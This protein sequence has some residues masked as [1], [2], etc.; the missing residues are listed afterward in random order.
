MAEAAVQRIDPSTPR[1][2]WEAERDDLE[3]VD[4]PG[5]FEG[6]GSREGGATAANANLWRPEGVDEDEDLEDEEGEWEYEDVSD[7]EEE[8]EE[9]EGEAEAEPGLAAELDEDD[10]EETDEEEFEYVE[11]GEGEELDDEGWEYEYVEVDEDEDDEDDELV[12]LAED[13]EEVDDDAGTPQAPAPEPDEAEPATVL[14]AAL[15]QTGADGQQMDLFAD[16]ED[17]A[18][19]AEAAA[20]VRG[21]EP[22]VVLEPQA[23]PAG[24]ASENARRAA[25]VILAESRVAVSLLQ[26]KF[27]MDFKE[28]CAVLDELQDLGFIGP[29]ID[30]KQRDILMGREEWL[31]AVGTG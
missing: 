23:P 4:V 22:V 7:L 9:D 6:D 24:L 29:Y 26:R 3:S 16:P 27:G 15:P 17:A 31:S 28:S 21:A 30:G 1:P 25:E 5:E 19:A 2:S 13:S 8:L 10:E 12:A 11:V 14:T 20:A 18:D